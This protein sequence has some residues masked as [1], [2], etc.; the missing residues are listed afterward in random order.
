MNLS[1]A[2]A[3]GQSRGFLYVRNSECIRRDK[4]MNLSVDLALCVR[5]FFASIGLL[6]SNIA[7]ADGAPLLQYLRADQ[8]ESS[9]AVADRKRIAD[10]RAHPF[11]RSVSVVS[12]DKAAL[13]ANVLVISTPSG[14]VLTFTKTTAETQEGVRYEGKK[15]AETFTTFI[16][17]GKSATGGEVVLSS[18]EGVISGTIRE[19]GRGV[20]SIRGLNAKYQMLSEIDVTRVEFGD[21]TPK[22]PKQ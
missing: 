8:E 17:A 3:L 1:V 11:I 12:I 19:R 9:L 21:D 20:L 22:R 16:W 2:R 18:S 6:A 10:E 7:L 14:E 15:I 5:V 13:L 4:I